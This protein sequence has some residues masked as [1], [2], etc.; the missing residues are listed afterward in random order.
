MTELDYG[1]AEFIVARFDG[2]RPSD[3]F[4][5]ALVDLVA[6]GTIRL[7]DL[8]F[9][10]RSAAGEV[11]LL[12]Y[13]DLGDASLTLEASGLA[14]SEDVDDIAELIEPGTSG[15]V[16]VLEHLWAKQ[17]ASAFFDTGGE[18]VYMERIPAP[19]VNA[20]LAEMSGEDEGGQRDPSADSASAAAQPETVA[21]N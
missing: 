16:I 11:E 8:V 13:E 17:L 3:E 21:G 1:P 5:R 20:L 15:A 7:L 18:V 4:W 10:S 14:G 19:A 12:E 6:T 9:V 2:D